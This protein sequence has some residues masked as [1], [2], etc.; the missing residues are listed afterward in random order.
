MGITGKKLTNDGTQAVII[1]KIVIIFNIVVSSH[2]WFKLKWGPS[3]N[4]S[5]SWAA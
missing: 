4:Q 1:E 5:K 2:C 3:R